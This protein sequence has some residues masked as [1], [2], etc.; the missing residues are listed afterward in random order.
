MEKEQSGKIVSLIDNKSHMFIG[1][2]WEYPDSNEYCVTPNYE[3]L[4]HGVNTDCIQMGNCFANIIKT[5]ESNVSISIII[6]KDGRFPK[7]IDWLEKHEGKIPPQQHPLLHN[8]IPTPKSTKS[9]SMA[10]H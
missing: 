2:L 10:T 9:Y 1:E 3:D 6:E 5:K 7:I 8:L 4:F